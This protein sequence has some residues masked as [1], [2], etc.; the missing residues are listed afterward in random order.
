MAGQASRWCFSHGK[1]N[2]TTAYGF[3]ER[4]LGTTPPGREPPDRC[5]SQS[6]LKATLGFITFRP[7]RRGLAAAVSRASG[8]ELSG[9][10]TASAATRVMKRGHLTGQAVGGPFERDHDATNHGQRKLS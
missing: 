6:E 3:I 8:I 5:R 7:H 9:P 1:C 10:E 2:G 4:G